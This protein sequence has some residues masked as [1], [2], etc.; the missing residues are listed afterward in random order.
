M[1]WCALLYCLPFLTTFTFPYVRTGPPASSARTV[2]S[3]SSACSNRATWY[4]GGGRGP[5][6]RLD[7]PWP[8][9]PHPKPTQTHKHTKSNQVPLDQPAA[10]LEM[11]N[12]FTGSDPQALQ[13]WDV[14][15]S[16]SPLKFRRGGL[17]SLLKP[18]KQKHTDGHPRW[19]ARKHPGNDARYHCCCC[20]CCRCYQRCRRARCAC[21]RRPEQEQQGGLEGEEGGSCGCGAGGCG[22]L[23]TR[24]EQCV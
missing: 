4:V 22:G 10:A 19:E 14:S 18:P 11:L 2:G 20:R 12:A 15:A 24:E 6:V 7:L 3:P 8:L 9:G 17:N 16:V 21:E 13:L 23:G 1:G 5:S